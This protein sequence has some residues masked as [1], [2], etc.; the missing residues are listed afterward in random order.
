MNT[1]DDKLVEDNKRSCS[2]LATYGIVSH[3][4]ETIGAKTILEVGAA[5]GYHAEYLLTSLPSIDYI[6]IDPY[7][8]NYDLNDI[9][10]SD[11]QR[12]FQELHGQDAMDRLFNVV[13]RK[14]SK[15]QGRAKLVRKK[16]DMGALDFADESIDLIYIDGDHTY[17][18][19]MK[20]LRAWWPKVSHE[21]GLIAGDDITWGGVKAACDDFFIGKRLEYR[22][23]SK[24]GYEALPVWY[25]DFQNRIL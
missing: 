6:G 9:F 11:V 4:A 2:W 22:L 3:L 16:S 15:F 25:F 14:L 1:H 21:K 19:V 12:I 7:T 10:S 8:A 5:Y 20:D 13:E 18:G 17:E 23:I 24:N